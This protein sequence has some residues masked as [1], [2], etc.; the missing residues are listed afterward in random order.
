MEL[1]AGLAL[2]TL[3]ASALQPL[4]QPWRPAM[5]SSLS[6]ALVLAAVVSPVEKPVASAAYSA[7]RCAAMR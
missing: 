7:A 4:H 2:A 3:A 5:V 1:F 6:P